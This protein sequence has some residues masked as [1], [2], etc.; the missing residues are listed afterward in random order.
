MLRKTKIEDSPV[1]EICER[2]GKTT[3]AEE[4]HH[5]LEIEKGRNRD[6]MI[7]RAFD[8]NN[9]QSLCKE[10][11]DR[12]HRRGFEYLPPKVHNKRKTKN[13]VDKYL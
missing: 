8:Y 1:C 10:C 12:V 11:H 13:F 9:L 4:V 3:I 7:R 2:S 6:D 5:I